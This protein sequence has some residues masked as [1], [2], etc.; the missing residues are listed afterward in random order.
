MEPS[1]EQPVIH[2]PVQILHAS[3]RPAAPHRALWHGPWGVLLLFGNASALV[4][5]RF[6]GPCAADDP[7][8]LPGAIPAPWGLQPTLQL[9]LSGTEFQLAVWRSLARL[10]HGERI[11]YSALAGRIGRPRAVRAVANAVAANPVPVL[12]PCHRVIRRD[13]GYGDYIGGALRKHRLIHWETQ[14]GSGLTCF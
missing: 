6:Q 8:A 3:I 4:G 14:N 13:G 11:S 7:A 12:L 2:M 9:A 5:A 1:L 10:G